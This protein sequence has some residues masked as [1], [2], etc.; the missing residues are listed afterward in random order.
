MP[1]AGTS[2]EMYFRT[3]LSP[4][5]DETPKILESRFSHG[6][7]PFFYQTIDPFFTK[8]TPHFPASNL[9]HSHTPEPASID[10]F[11]LRSAA[12]VAG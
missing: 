8:N 11:A 2:A 4:I 3:N 9:N 1:I 5:V 10:P 6:F 7:A 12:A